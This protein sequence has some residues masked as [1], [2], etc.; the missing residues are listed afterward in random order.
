MNAVSGGIQSIL[1]GT[2]LKTS[3]NGFMT[4]FESLEYMNLDAVVIENN[5][6]TTGLQIFVNCPKL[7][8]YPNFFKKFNTVKYITF[9]SFNNTF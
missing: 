2:N 1:L 7:G 8:F 5:S 3:T 4:N 9:G 6:D